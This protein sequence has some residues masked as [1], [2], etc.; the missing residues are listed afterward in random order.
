MLLFG[1]KLTFLKELASV[2]QALHGGKLIS[3]EASL[4]VVLINLIHVI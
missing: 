4:K 2:L 1:L 3:L